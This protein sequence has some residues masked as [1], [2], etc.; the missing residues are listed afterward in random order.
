MTDPRVLQGYYRY[1]LLH[2]WLKRK[3]GP[4]CSR[5]I[6]SYAHKDRV[7]EYR[8]VKLLIV[9]CRR[10]YEGDCLYYS[11]LCDNGIS[12]RHYAFMATRLVLKF[13]SKKIT[14]KWPYPGF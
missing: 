9:C 2:H 8:K 5:M 6:I 13:K 4:D 1:R 10:F 12:M 3:V 14:Y 11:A 7:E